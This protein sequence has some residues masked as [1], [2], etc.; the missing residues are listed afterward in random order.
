MFVSKMEL[1]RRNGRDFK[2][3]S[4]AALEAKFGGAA[5]ALFSGLSERALQDP[6]QFATELSKTFGRGSLG[7]LEPIVKF[8]DQ[9]LFP[10]AQPSVSAAAALAGQLGPST[11]EDA[12]KTVP[13]H[14]QR[15]KDDEEKYADDY[16]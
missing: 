16:D 3:G 6:N 9:D 13:L 15:L 2:A 12:S 4:R 8:A 11:G 14:E 1:L 5:S 7:F 10:K